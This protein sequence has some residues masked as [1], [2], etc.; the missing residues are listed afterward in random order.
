MQFLVLLSRDPTLLYLEM[1][2]SFKLSMMHHP[3]LSDGNDY[4]APVQLLLCIINLRTRQLVS[5]NLQDTLSCSVKGH[6]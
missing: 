5:F 3:S 2:K 1:L 6:H 4:R